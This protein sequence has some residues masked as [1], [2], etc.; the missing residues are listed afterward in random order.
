MKVARDLPADGNQG[1]NSH[2]SLLAS[3]ALPSFPYQAILI[4]THKSSLSFILSPFSRKG[5]RGSRGG[6]WLLVG[7][8]LSQEHLLSMIHEHVQ[9]ILMDMD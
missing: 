1:M 5:A 6:V 9:D 8:S 4:S 3:A 7:V 2:F